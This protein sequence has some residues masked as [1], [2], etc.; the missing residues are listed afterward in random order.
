[1]AGLSFSWAVGEGYFTRAK[2]I[3]TKNGVDLAPKDA[4]G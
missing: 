4:Q 1:M 2:L 3:L